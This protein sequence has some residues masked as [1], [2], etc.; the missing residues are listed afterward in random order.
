[1]E[2]TSAENAAAAPPPV[3]VPSAD[4][5]A[6]DAPT[7]AQPSPPTSSPD[8]PQKPINILVVDTGP[9]VKNDP[10]IS[11]LLAKA[12]EIYTLPSVLTEIRDEATRTRVD[13]QLR[14][15]LKL[16]NPR[17]ESIQFVTAFARRTGDLE[18]L[19]KPD[20]H[21]I[22]LTYELE[23]EKNGGDWRLR[24][25]PNQKGVNGKSPAQLAKDADQ[26]EQGEGEEEATK[27]EP[28][29][30]PTQEESDTVAPT[31]AT[32]ATETA[33]T[34]QPE[35]APVVQQEE[36]SH[37]MDELKLDPA[38]E[39]KPMSTD[40]EEI[41]EAANAEEDDDDDGWITPSNLKKHKEKDQL[42]APEA[43]IHK[44]LQVALLT[45]DF[46]MQNVTMRIN[47]NLLSPSMARI[48][49]VKQWVLR[50]HGCFQ[51]TRK[52]EKQFCPKCGQPTLT[53]VSCTTDQHGKFTL[54]L[55]KNF[56]FNKRGNVYSIPKPVHGTANTKYRGQGG[57]RG[58][59]GTELLLAEDQKEYTRKQD[60][61]R[62]AKARDLMDEDYLPGILTGNRQGAGGAG[63]IKVG[64]GRGINAK[65][66]NH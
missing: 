46:A 21:L 61:N 36:I 1:M 14:P 44:V 27:L 24:K 42:A 28:A 33:P 37:Q 4:V 54:H 49:R 11:T 63:R 66:R 60:E 55:K 10:S 65:K 56:Q 18:V 64:A 32:S 34:Q 3:E 51:V 25:E 16:R 31:E 35:D 57:G 52:M 5:P 20:L 38:S 2:T 59:W 30:E 45:S 50:C 19:S 58:G 41:E 53:R 17:P 13:T 6:G 9:L 7:D 48:T 62:R 26:H 23:C 43:P 12:T 8:V 22:A 39:T 47:L 15:F 40:P 29:G